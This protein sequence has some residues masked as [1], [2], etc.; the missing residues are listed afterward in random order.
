MQITYGVDSDGDG[1]ANQYVAANNG[2]VPNWTQV[3]SVRIS[4]TARSVGENA[5][6]LTIASNPPRPFNG[7][8]VTDRRLIRSF[9]T[10]IGLRNRLR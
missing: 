1:S 9:T 5:D 2:A 7:S 6:N 8:N 4:L 3:V 10:T